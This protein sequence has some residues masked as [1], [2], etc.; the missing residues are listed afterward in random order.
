LIADSRDGLRE[1]RKDQVLQSC[2][3]CR[4]EF[5]CTEVCPK[6]ISPTRAIKYIQRQAFVEAFQK[7]TEK[8]ALTETEV[9]GTFFPVV[10]D[11]SRRKFLKR[12]TYTIG[13]VTAVLVGGVLVSSAVVPSL[14]K[15]PRVWVYAG[16]VGDFEP[17]K[18]TTVNL[19][20]QARDGFYT[21]RKILPVMITPKSGTDDIVVYSSRCTHLGCTV[22]WDDE[23]RLYLCA[24]HGG[25]FNPDGSVKAG[26]P[27]EPLMRCNYKVENG[28][29]LV[30][31]V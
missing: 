21:S 25:I 28:A 4:T 19:R 2:Y 9:E 14:R 5:N 1:K 22:R 15:S 26:P 20:Y 8:P 12:V 27:P 29:L 17:N 18:V 24:C 6:E 30:E 23:K 16:K 31:V 13:A 3:T 10:Q 11:D 7:R